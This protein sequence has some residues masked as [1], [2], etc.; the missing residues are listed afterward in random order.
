MRGNERLQF[1]AGRPPA[2][3]C[4]WRRA[5][6]SL[7]FAATLLVAL[8]LFSLTQTS[9]AAATTVNENLAGAETGVPQPSSQ[10]TTQSNNVVLSPFA[11]G[12]GGSI[13]GGWSAGACHANIP[14]TVG[15]SVPLLPGGSFAVN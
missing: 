15:Q 13:V 3:T 11:G 12:A 5:V 8:G 9:A 4:N 6:R 14:G 7:R 2:S 10:C 1:R